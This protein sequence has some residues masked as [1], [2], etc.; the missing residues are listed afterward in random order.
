MRITVRNHD[1]YQRY[2]NRTPPWIKLYRKI[3]NNREYTQL[4]D[5]QWRLGI[6]VLLLATED[7]SGVL[8][9][10][11][12]DLLFRLHRKI[13]PADLQ[14]LESVGFI[15]IGEHD[16]HVAH[17]TGVQAAHAEID[18]SEIETE[19]E[20]ETDGHRRLAAQRVTELWGKGFDKLWKH[21]P[22][23]VSKAQARRTW[24]KLK[25]TNGVD[26]DKLF[27]AIV[28]NL[29]ER[30]REWRDRDDDKV[31]HMSTWLNA[32]EFNETRR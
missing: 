10:T 23:K 6:E 7:G 2:R 11:I 13:K 14:A 32:E 30:V 24:M 28:Q 29:R 21:Y 5:S 18:N 27:N 8:E 17:T 4:T 22:R 1:K 9:C 19:V 26:P 12:E 20:T 31:P 16:A 25:P 3:L 15:T